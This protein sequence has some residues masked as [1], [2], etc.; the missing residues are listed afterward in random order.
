MRQNTHFVSPFSRLR[1]WVDTTVRELYVFL[2]LLILMP[3]CRKPTISS[4][5]RNDPLLPTPI[6]N[7]YMRRDRFRAVLTFLQFANRDDPPDNYNNDRIWKVREVYEKLMSRYQ[8]YFYPF[9]RL[10]IDESLVLFKGRLNFKQYIP[11]KVHRFGIKVF[12]LCD[13]ETG[14][15][16]NMIVYTGT[17][18]DIP[19]VPRK[20]PFGMSGTIVKK[21][22]LP[23]LGKG[24]IL[25]TDNW[26]TSP[27]LCQFL[28]DNKTGSCGTVKKTRKFMPKFTSQMTKVDDPAS[29]DEADENNDQQQR[30]PRQLLRRKKNR[31]IQREKS[32]KVLA[33]KWNDKRAVHLLTT[34]HKGAIVE[35]DKVHHRTKKR[36]LKPD[37]VVDYTKNMRLVDKGDSQLSTTEC[38]RKSSKW[39]IKFF[40]HLIDRTM[41]NAYNLWLV[42]VDMEPT[43]KLKLRDFVYNVSYQ[44]LEEFGEPTSVN[45]G[46]PVEYMPDRI[47]D[48]IE[49]HYLVHTEKVNGLRKSGVSCVR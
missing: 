15:T 13:C 24:H 49:R 35:T 26:Y 30:R 38:L 42:K 47:V 4:Y 2:A 48:G 32:G 36:I 39:Y 23:Y 16:L 46:R 33:I 20:D 1:K 40:M 12:V 25:Y 41:L 44:L 28:H 21:M 45:K 11:S 22:M 18:I 14:Y 8:K 6:F 34:V 43:K 9:K 10:V 3:L 19:K 27:V 5:W 37:L 29:S 17:D 7:K 31:Y